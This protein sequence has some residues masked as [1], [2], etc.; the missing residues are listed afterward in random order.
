MVVLRNHVPFVTL[1]DKR[2]NDQAYFHQQEGSL[3][4]SAELYLSSLRSEITDEFAINNLSVKLG[5]T[6][7]FELLKT[8]DAYSLVAVDSLSVVEEHIRGTELNWFTYETIGEDERKT[9]TLQLMAGK[10]YCH[11]PRL[12]SA[13]PGSSFRTPWEVIELR[14]EQLDQGHIVPDLNKYLRPQGALIMEFDCATQKSRH[15]MRLIKEH[16]RFHPTLRIIFVSCRIVHAEDLYADLSKTFP[17]ASGVKFSIY[18]DRDVTNKGWQSDRIVVQLN[19]IPTY[20]GKV[21]NIVVLDEICSILSFFTLNNKTMTATKTTAS[22]RALKRTTVLEHSET[23]E[24]MSRNCDKLVLADAHAS[25]DG[26]V[27]DFMDGVNTKPV[28]HLK[29]LGK[30]PACKRTLRIRFQPGSVQVPMDDVVRM[31]AERVLQDP[32]QRIYIFCGAESFLCNAHRGAGSYELTL[33]KYGVDKI[34]IVIGNTGD[35]QKK[36]IVEDLDAALQG[37]Q[38][39]LTNSAVTVGLNPRVKFGTVI[40]HTHQLGACTDDMFQN[41]QRVGRADG[42]LADQTIYM[43][44]HDKSPEE[45]QSE[46]E[47]CA[48]DKQPQ[49]ANRTFRQSRGQVV[50]KL[51]I[52]RAHNCMLAGGHGTSSSLSDWVV[53]VAAHNEMRRHNN[54][55][56]HI[57]EILRF[58]MFHKW[59]VE[60]NPVT[61]E[62]S[63]QP[64]DCPMDVLNDNS[65]IVKGTYYAYAAVVPLFSPYDCTEVKPKCWTFEKRNRDEGLSNDNSV[66]E[67]LSHWDFFQ[68]LQSVDSNADDMQVKSAAHKRIEDLYFKTYVAFGSWMNPVSEEPWPMCLMQYIYEH[69]S[70]IKNRAMQMLEEYVSVQRI[71]DRQKIYTEKS[72]IDA[73]T[74]TASCRTQ[75]GLELKGFLHL[76]SL[77]HEWSIP[78]SLLDVMKKQFNSDTYNDRFEGDVPLYG[79]FRRINSDVQFPPNKR[80][81]SALYLDLQKVMGRFGMVLIWD[82]KT[83]KQRPYRRS[84][85]EGREVKILHNNYRFVPQYEMV[86]NQYLITHPFDSCVKLRVSDLVQELSAINQSHADEIIREAVRDYEHVADIT[87]VQGKETYTELFDRETLEKLDEMTKPLVSSTAIDGRLLS[88][89]YN[90][91][92]ARRYSIK[93]GSMKKLREDIAKFM[94]LP[95]EDGIG[96]NMVHYHYKFG[97]GL[98]RRYASGV[99]YQ[100]ISGSLRKVL[101]CKFYYDIDNVNSYP[102]ILI[103]AC[104]CTD[105]DISRIQM[106]QRYGSGDREDLLREVMVYYNVDRDAA[107]NCF[108]THCHGGK[109]DGRKWIDENGKQHS[110]GW[111]NKWDVSDAVRLKVSN[112][113]HLPSVV[114]FAEECDYVCKHLLGKFPEYTQTLNQVNNRLPSSKQKTG[115]MGDYSALS[116]LMAT[117]EDELLQHLERFLQSRGYTVDSLEFDGL[118]PRRKPGQEGPFDEQTLRDAEEYLAHQELR[119]GVKIPMKLSEKPLVSPF[120]FGDN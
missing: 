44:V 55:S 97:D 107:K 98:G 12:F 6:A 95:H 56:K 52:R 110:T 34:K 116:Y 26:R 9:N 102:T 103:H 109:M 42:L 93:P 77:V 51:E 8:E 41:L 24:E 115:R 20:R 114:Q 85:Q 25:M 99:S 46:S 1:L 14:P 54:R 70:E 17:F 10:F 84:M 88:V 35:D 18:K 63:V 94:E 64:M 67:Y 117:L 69:Q 37:C 65:W 92:F 45:K 62:S 23:I 73:T 29:G 90:E 66:G 60:F 2:E 38:A 39:F 28:V 4:T 72:T 47:N 108:L 96:Q 106:F 33:R 49:D 3:A 91:D 82:G 16:L 19:S 79:I 100:G 58:A 74:D 71:R 40:A 5:E 89:E 30:N 15:I 83:A 75:A 31:A 112:E 32:E 59:K 78:Q 11:I 104:K 76:S 43:C 13:D 36:A 120:Q 119:G 81:T 118:K 7:G 101:A 27:K 111:M 80:N 105:G 113:G 50:G 87:I 48:L 22:G 68:S 53:N 61:L 21:Y 86:S 57:E